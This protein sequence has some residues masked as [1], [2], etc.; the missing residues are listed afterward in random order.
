[1]KR[2]ALAFAVLAGCSSGK[3]APTLHVYTWENYFA[4]DTIATF[5][6]ETGCTVKLD[7]M[8]SAEDLKTKLDGGK[9]G[10]DV[11]MPSDEVLSSLIGQG[12]L[13]K[14]D[15]AKVPNLKNVLAKHRGLPFDPKNEYSVPYQWGTTGIAYNKEKIVPP[16]DSWA[17]FW[18]PRWANRVSLLND[19]REVF[20]AAM[21]LDGGDPSVTTA[22][23]IAKAAKRFD[24]W[25]PLAYETT[26]KDKLVSGD[27]WISQSYSG[28]AVQAAE[29][30]DGKIGYVIPKEGGTLWL[31][32]LAIARGAPN[33]DLAHKFIDYILR[34]EVSAAIT[35]E[36]Y[37]GSP[38]EAALKL[39]KKEVLD[40]RMAYPSDQDQKRLS[41]LPALT[42]EVKKALDAAWAS[43]RG[44]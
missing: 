14:I 20:A 21:R 30:S 34:P 10:F 18:D 31:D 1:M 22:D 16:P 5:E 33:T 39:I 41:M 42:P 12:M 36:R 24:G 25:R 13:E 32:N 43:I 2:L 7:F 15:P 23:R 37:F 19:K 38:N 4:K 9:S 40:N 27:F 28:D 17:A 44:K 11:V 26:P 3:S 29:G 6:K 35:N 8:E